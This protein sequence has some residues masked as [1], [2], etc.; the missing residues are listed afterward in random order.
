MEKQKCPFCGK[1]LILEEGEKIATCPKCKT[2]TYFG[3]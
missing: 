1:T 3:K 2:K